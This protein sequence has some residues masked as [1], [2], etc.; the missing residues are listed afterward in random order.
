MNAS[1]VAGA[2]PNKTAAIASIEQ[3]EKIALGNTFTSVECP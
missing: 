2:A 3:Q 1:E